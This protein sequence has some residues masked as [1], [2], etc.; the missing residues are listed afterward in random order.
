MAK[1]IVLL[2]DGT[3]NGAAKRN[4]TNVWRLYDALDLHRNDQIAFYD[5]GVG[6]QEF[7]LFKLLGGAFGW[8]LKRNVLQ[9][10]QFLCR[11]YEP[12][13]RIYLFGFSRGAFTIRLLAGMIN[14]CGIYKNNKYEENHEEQ[15]EKVAK[16]NYNAFRSKFKK[17]W[18]T[19]L[20]RKFTGKTEPHPSGEEKDIEFVG[21]WDTVD[22]YGLPMDWMAELFNQ[23]IYPL[24]F[25]DFQL[26]DNVKKA[27][28]AL[29][30]DDERKTF[31]PVLWDERDESE[32]LEQVW[33]P[34]VHSDVG[35][36]Y[37][38]YNLALISLDWMISK[39]EEN[40]EGNR[41]GLYFIDHCRKEIHCHS[42][43]NGA[44]H[45]SRSILGTYYRYSPRDIHKICTAAD[46]KW[47]IDLP[48]IHR[49]VFKRISENA[50]PY[51][52]TGIPKAYS[53]VSTRNSPEDYE[54][55]VE[56]NVRVEKMQR[57]VRTIKK[58]KALYYLFLSI[59]LGLFVLPIL[60]K[61]KPISMATNNLL[62]T[63]LFEMFRVLLPNFASFWLDAWEKVP[64]LFYTAMV[65]FI[66]F[67]LAKLLLFKKT[68]VY[69]SNA[70]QTLKNK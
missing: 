17:G 26:P 25:P 5:D 34:G 18:L 64:I 55:N 16:D 52:P 20:I 51:A 8:G 38:K 39:V 48:K 37:P 32:R 35:G 4:K 65:F 14:Y 54:T 46:K 21:V 11:N 40:A 57:A 27:C 7:I 50:V 1:N 59:S 49:S 66:V 15:L 53:I 63:K 44:Q 23:F 69:A 3:G 9:L 41:P 58:R 24:R 12:G 33:F 60:D 30:V 29:S 67:I 22:A 62:H 45:E 31:H 56:K 2:S 42:D 28:H 61:F 36:G 19:Q 47:R 70:W 6:S 43:W 68:M 10:Y 13:D